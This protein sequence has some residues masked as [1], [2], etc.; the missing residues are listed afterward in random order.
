MQEKIPFVSWKACRAHRS[1]ASL[2]GVFA[3][4]KHSANAGPITAPCDIMAEGCACS[5]SSMR[6]IKFKQY[7]SLKK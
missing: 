3:S 6:N 4:F 2:T 5:V 7:N 1:A